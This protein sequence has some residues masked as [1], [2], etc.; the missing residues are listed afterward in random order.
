MKLNTKNDIH[1]LM[2]AHLPSAVLNAAFERGLFWHLTGG[3]KPV[4][5]IAQE[6]QIPTQRCQYW[7][8][9][10]AGLNLLVQEGD[11]FNLSPLAREAI[12]G[13]HSRETWQMLA[14]DAWD[15]LEESLC[16]GQRLGETIPAN[17]RNGS[18]FNYLSPYVQK[19]S[20]DPERARKFTNMLFELH[21][22]LAQNIAAV[23]D[24]HDVDSVLDVGGGSGVVSLALLKKY[25]EL[26]AVVVDIPNVC[27]AGRAIAKK[28]P[29]H[30]RIAYYSADFVLDELPKGFD[31]VM[32]CDIGQYDGLPLTKLLASLNEGGRLVIVDTWFER[33][34]EETIGRLG[35]LL[36]RSLREPEF[37]LRSL[38]VFLADLVEA[39]LEPETVV[40]LPYKQWKLISAKKKVD[41]IQGYPTLL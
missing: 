18:G 37:S 8:R 21:T 41:L 13:T 12:I 29:E 6:M 38:P 15:N 36:R 4:T 5:Q 22:P 20:A 27:N 9:F 30:D 34:E 26:C 33:G 17:D 16:L 23:L 24:L 40:E 28:M 3:S 7:L 19:M 10:L 31:I 39:G 1:E 25:P 11:Q 32:L 2:D 35:Y 14:I